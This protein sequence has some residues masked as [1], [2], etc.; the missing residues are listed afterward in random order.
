M[1]GKRGLNVALSSLRKIIDDLKTSSSSTGQPDF[2]VSLIE[3][4]SAIA[5]ALTA[6]QDELAAEASLED[7]KN[8]TRRP[9]R[10][11]A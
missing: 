6:Y 5:D 10:R 1:S 9:A 2:P 11:V 7:E 3:E 4:L 8:R